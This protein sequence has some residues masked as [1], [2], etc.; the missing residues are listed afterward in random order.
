[1]L[2]SQP[3]PISRQQLAR[4]DGRRSTRPD[5]LVQMISDYEDELAKLSENPDGLD[6][7]ETGHRGAD[8]NSCKRPSAIWRDR[9]PKRASSGKS[10]TTVTAT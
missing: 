10:V 3:V 7:E 8:S 6:A 5:V 2:H 4:H 1:M 9:F